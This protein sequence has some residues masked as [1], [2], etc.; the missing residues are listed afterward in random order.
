MNNPGS[1][2]QGVIG[3]AEDQPKKMTTVDADNGRLRKEL[4][5]LCKNL[6]AVEDR[7]FVRGGA[8]LVIRGK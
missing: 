4:E 1:N 3:M 5:Q 8:E 2:V 7:S 6:R